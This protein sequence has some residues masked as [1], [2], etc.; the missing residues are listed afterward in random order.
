MEQYAH[1]HGGLCILTG[2]AVLTDRRVA[3][4]QA[5]TSTDLR[6]VQ[7]YVYACLHEGVLATLHISHG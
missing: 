7:L 5:V 1:A 3:A 6:L 2:L 4:V